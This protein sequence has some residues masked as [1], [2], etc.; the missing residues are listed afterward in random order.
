MLK[1]SLTEEFNNLNDLLK[2]LNKRIVIIIDDFDRLQA[3]E[4]FEILKLIRNTAGFD[5]FTYV[6][7]YDKEYLVKSL[8]N[9]N[10]PNPEKFTEK[11]FLREIELLPVT[12]IQINNSLKQE[13]LKYFPSHK[14][15]IDDFL[16][17]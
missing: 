15:D 4:I 10:I 6:V 7:A 2:K 9:N 8:K 11:I 3:N 14:N 16:M 1:S 13:L 5:T 17:V 12:N